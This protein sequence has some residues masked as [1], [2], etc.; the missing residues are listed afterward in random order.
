MN[1]ANQFPLQ[2]I[3]PK[4]EG[5]IYPHALSISIDTDIE[6]HKVESFMKYIISYCKFSETGGI[7]EIPKGVFQSCRFGSGKRYLT[8][9]RALEESGVLVKIKKHNADMHECSK[10]KLIDDFL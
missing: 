10:Y 6:L 3:T 1:V 9:K 8:L 2:L 5:I 4:D 7:V